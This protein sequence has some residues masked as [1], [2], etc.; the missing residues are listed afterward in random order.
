MNG[1]QKVAKGPQLWPHPSLLGFPNPAVR[2]PFLLL[3]E[4]SADLCCS[5]WAES[6]RL[7]ILLL[8]QTLKG[9]G[10]GTEN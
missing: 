10:Q 9:Q 2:L 5:L 1:S 3:V 8:L 6:C 4:S 7:H